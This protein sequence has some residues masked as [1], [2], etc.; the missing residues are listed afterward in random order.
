MTTNGDIIFY[1]TDKTAIVVHANSNIYR[2]STNEKGEYGISETGKIDSTAKKILVTSTTSTLTDGTIITYYSDGSAKVEYKNQTLF[3]RDS[4]NIKLDNGNTLNNLMPSGVAPVNV[5]SD[6]GTNTIITFTDKTSLVIKNGKKY[7]INKNTSISTT[8]DTINYN[9]YNSFAIISEKTYKDGNIITHFENGTAI[10][11]EPNGN[12]TYIKKSGDLLLKSQKLYEIV[13]ND[14]GYSMTTRNIFDGKKVTYFDNGAA[15]IINTDGNRQYIDNSD[16]I[17]YDESKSIISNPISSKQVS[18][19]T[20]NA[21]EKAI[22]FENGK[23]QIIRSN[24]KSYITDTSKLT[25]KPT[26]TPAEEPPIEN[27]ESS[28]GGPN[29]NPGEGIYISEAENKYND[30]KNIETT[31]FIIKNNNITNKVLRITIEEVTKYQNYNTSRLDPKFVKFQATIGDNYIPATKLTQNSWI[32]SS[33][34]TNYIIYEGNINAKES[35]QIALSLYIDYAELDNSH[36]NKGFI[37]T[38]RVYVDNETEKSD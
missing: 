14:S 32:N 36:Q 7:I 6:V 34:T 1:Y 26:E 2:I 8:E 19:K 13:P 9:E 38:I 3:V 22:N 18:E 15:I 28:H 10:I 27:G 33:G 16:D 31:K 4:N 17:I 23:S 20:T 29:K 5:T 25:F 11:I 30:F 37:G 12:I 35:K 21:G 24:G